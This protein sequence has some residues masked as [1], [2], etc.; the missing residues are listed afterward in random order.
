MAAELVGEAQ[1]VRNMD[2]SMGAEDFSFMLQHKPGAYLRLGQ[3]VGDDIIPLHNNRYDFNDDVLPLGAALHA[4][5]V[6]RGM[7]L[8][9]V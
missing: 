9:S 7:P 3:A 8:A 6:E 2:P 4:G 1:V 5:I